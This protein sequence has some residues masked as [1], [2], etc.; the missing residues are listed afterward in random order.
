MFRTRCQFRHLFRSW[1]GAD[2]ERNMGWNRIFSIHI[3]LVLNRH[4]HFQIDRPKK[5]DRNHSE[6]YVVPSFA[7][8]MAGTNLMKVCSG[9]DYGALQSVHILQS[10]ASSAKHILCNCQ[11]KKPFVLSLS[12]YELLRQTPFDRLRANGDSH[13]LAH[14]QFGQIAR[15]ALCLGHKLRF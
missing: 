5:I 15:L 13:H 11:L 8:L 4:P 1:L 9:L 12:K 14:Q 6:S 2:E 7:R 10:S 3:H